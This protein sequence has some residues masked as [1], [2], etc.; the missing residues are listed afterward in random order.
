MARGFF[1]EF[2]KLA[3][4]IRTSDAGN[5]NAYPGSV[6]KTPALGERKK[7]HVENNYVGDGRMDT[8]GAALGK[9]TYKES[10]KTKKKVGAGVTGDDPEAA[11]ISVGGGS[12]AG[13]ATIRD[14]V[15]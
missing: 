9:D 14:L 1:D 6:A 10:L 5:T 7:P 15:G 13:F 11:A 3:S 4:S 12:P 2:N 8:A